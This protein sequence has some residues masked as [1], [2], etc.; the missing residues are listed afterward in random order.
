MSFNE[1]SVEIKTSF[2]V[3]AIVNQII[4]LNLNKNPTSLKQNYYHIV[5]DKDNR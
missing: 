5:C 1:C 4:F 2:L 3:F